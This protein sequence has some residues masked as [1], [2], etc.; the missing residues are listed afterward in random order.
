MTI[1]PAIDLRNGKCVRLYQGRADAETVYFD[2][3]SAPA[4]KWKEAGAKWLHLVD[5]DG[6]F[7]GN[8][9]NLDAVRN[10]LVTSGLRAQLGGG[11]RDD[12]AV[13]AV[14]DAGVE[15]AIIG[16]RACSEPDW[17]RDL[18]EKFGAD[19]IAAGIDARDGM[20]TTKGWVETTQTD[21]LALARK[22]AGLGVRWIIHTDVATDGAMQGP[23]LPAQQAIAEAVPSCKIIAS[24]GVTR[25]QDLVDLRALSA[26]L[27][28][29][30]GVIVGKAL[31]EG[32]V[33]LSQALS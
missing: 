31:Y 8:S 22:L 19:R 13:K 2:D 9:A 26:R 28:N 15:R 29:L 24:G 11:L 17:M 5:L 16:T 25:P 1:Y 10:V 21:A 4:S 33:D 6:A 27:P 3:P 7:D 32:T 23:N 12:A 18:V 14:L 20:V 30:E